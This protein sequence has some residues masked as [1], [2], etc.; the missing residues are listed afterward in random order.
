MRALLHQTRLPNQNMD[1]RNI[2]RNAPRI[3]FCKKCNK[4]TANCARE[5]RQPKRDRQ[6]TNATDAAPQEEYDDE[7]DKLLSLRTRLATMQSIYDKS[8]NGPPQ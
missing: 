7:T 4:Q 5:C 2:M 6:W 8:R 3:V 1:S